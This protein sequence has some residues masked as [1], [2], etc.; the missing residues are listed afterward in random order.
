MNKYQET[1]KWMFQQLPMYQRQG[2]SAFK[3]N[4]DNILALM[5]SLGNPHE[6][7]KCIHVGG[8]NGKGSVSHILSALLQTHGYSVGLYT[9]PH[10][11][12]FRERIKINTELITE[13]EVIDFVAHNKEAIERIQPSFFEITVAM[14]FQHFAKHQPDYVIMEVGL[15][16][17]LDS[18]NIIDP[19]LSVITNISL[20]HQSMLGDNL[21]QIAFEKAGIIKKDRPII[22]GEHQ[23]EVEYVFRE[24]ADEMCSRL[25]YAS[26]WLDLRLRSSSPLSNR[27]TASAVDH[28]WEIKCSTDLYG[29]YQENN[30][31]TALASF[32]QLAEI[33]PITIQIKSITKA[34]GE[35]K[36]TSYMLGRWHILDQKPLTLADSAHNE[37]GIRQLV[38]TI[39]SMEYDQ[40]HFIYGTANDKDLSNILPLLPKNAKY[41]YCKANIPRGKD[42]LELSE[43][44]KS[45]GL[46]GRPYGSVRQALGSAQLI[47]M[48]EDLIVVAGSI[49]VVAEII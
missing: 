14:A 26:D 10:Y 15:G 31:K 29:D 24:K 49:F 22:I 37:D 44:A 13:S 35:V 41:Y 42:A 30:L 34:L 48:E 46:L 32:M 12:D 8:T 6:Q 19:I 7:L 47:A 4:L 23:A 21:P 3:K 16:G 5:E 27:I 33:E 20:D 25:S 18:T 17:R 1:L 40:L 43:I 39:D 38:N 11:K 2:K 9:S 45:Y 28:S 36:K